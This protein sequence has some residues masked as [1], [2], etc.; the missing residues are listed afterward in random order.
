MNKKATE[1]ILKYKDLTTEIQRMWDVKT[2][3]IQL[4]TGASGAI[5]KSFVKKHPINIPGKKI[6]RTTENSHNGHCTHNSESINVKAQ[7][8]QHENYHYMYHKL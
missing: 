7:N 1:K 4:I 2:E 6:N 8:I 5:S 3:V